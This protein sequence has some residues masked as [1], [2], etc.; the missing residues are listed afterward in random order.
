MHWP[1][2][3]QCLK[4]PY[5]YINR[6]MGALNRVI[7]ELQHEWNLRPYIVASSKNRVKSNKSVRNGESPDL[8]CRSVCEKFNTFG[9]W[10]SKG[11]QVKIQNHRESRD[12]IVKVPVLYQTT[13][14][15]IDHT[16]SGDLIIKVRPLLFSTEE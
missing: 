6:C 15:Y 10:V 8:L 11:R 3:L 2:E 14:G 1:T 5:P 4:T 13:S 12:Y 7:R 9:S 16:S